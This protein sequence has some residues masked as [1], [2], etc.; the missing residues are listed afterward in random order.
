DLGN[1]EYDATADN[2]A[3]NSASSGKRHGFEEEL[4]G[5]VAAARADGFAHADFARALRDGYQHDVHH[6]HTANQQADRAEHDDHQHDAANDVVKFLHHFH[7]RLNGEVVGLIVGNFAAAAQN[8]ADLIHRGVEFA[9]IR[10]KAIA[11]LIA[12]GI[13]LHESVVRDDGA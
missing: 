9:G 12:A 11:D 7:L 2:D 13:Q 3:D 8:F 10:E 1:Q 4:P 5:D 6:T